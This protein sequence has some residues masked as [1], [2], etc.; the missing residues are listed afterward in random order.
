ML[1]SFIATQ[2]RLLQE[3]GK[4]ASSM[5]EVTTK[6][7][8]DIQSVVYDA[9]FGRLVKRRVETAIKHMKIRPNDVVLDLGIGTGASLSFFP[10]D[11]G[12]IVGIDL[13][14]GMLKVCKQKVAETGRTNISLF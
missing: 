9:T 14:S 8:Y 10:M 7:I 4:V 5:Q 1:L 2:I 12:R 13:S 3:N 11:K 6:Q